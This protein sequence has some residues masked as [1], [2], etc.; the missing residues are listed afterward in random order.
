M[1]LY[2]HLW[3]WVAIIG[4]GV[5]TAVTRSFFLLT[6][7]KFQF[8]PMIRRALRYA[9]TAAISAVIAP[10]VLLHNHAVDLT[11]HNNALVATVLASVVF[12]W[13]Q[14]LLLM[15]AV[16]MLVFTVLRLYVNP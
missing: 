12:V 15:I 2:E 9:P 11:W 8:S 16:G 6:P 1:S 13:K 14:N 4:L 5:V 3:L 10:S 7:A